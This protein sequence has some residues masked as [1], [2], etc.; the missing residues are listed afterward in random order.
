MFFIVV[1]T[2]L[3]L[4]QLKIYKGFFLNDLPTDIGNL[5]AISTNLIVLV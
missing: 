1:I 2:Y 3:G 4:H 5:A